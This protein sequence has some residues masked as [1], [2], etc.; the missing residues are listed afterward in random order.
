MQKPSRGDWDPE[1]SA[2]YWIN[3][4]SRTIVRQLD[5]SLRPHG[6][7]MSYLPVL[8]VLADGTARSQ[9]ELAAAA[10]VEQPSMAETL[11]RM[12]R[13]GV[14]ER[15]P[16]PNDRRG[17]LVSVTR[18]ARTRFPKAREA[19]VA[20]ERNAMAGLSPE[21]HATLRALRRRVVQNLE[22]SP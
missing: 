3:R 18:L 21:E 6:F 12:V 10:G 20:A 19:I 7:A 5:A 16:N 11:V 1:A 2:G 14:V 22:K 17:S 8:G 15:A 13:D 9:T 4:A